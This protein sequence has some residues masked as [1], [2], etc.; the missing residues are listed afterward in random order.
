L[1]NYPN[2]R[3]VGDVAIWL[4]TRMALER[5]SVRIRYQAE[6]ATYRRRLL[7][8]AVGDA[9]TILLPGGGN[10]GDVYPHPHRVRKQ[11]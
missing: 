7:A 4:G 5:A 1:V 9:G 8:S 11:D 3:N 6:P 2:L 10:L